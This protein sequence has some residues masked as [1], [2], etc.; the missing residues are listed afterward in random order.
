M[1]EVVNID[2]RENL[3]HVL[4]DLNLEVNLNQKSLGFVIDL[5]EE[6]IEVNQLEVDS[7][8]NQVDHL[9]HQE[10]DN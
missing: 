6:D 10:L 9:V 8:E 1:E 3:N 7:V 4:N 5:L 2:Q